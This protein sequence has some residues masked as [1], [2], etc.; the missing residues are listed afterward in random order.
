MRKIVSTLFIIVLILLAVGLVLLS[1]AG[2]IRA[3]SIYSDPHHFIKQ[4]IKWIVASFVLFCIAS[5]FDYRNFK[6]YSWITIGLYLGTAFLLALTLPFPGNPF[7]HEA[8]GSFRWLSIAGHPIGQPSEFAKIAI[9]ISMSVWMAKIGD[10]IRNP[11][12]GVLVPMLLI[13]GFAGSLILEPDFGAA[14]VVGVVALAVMFVAGTRILHLI[15]VAVVG[16]S[17]LGVVVLNNPN[18]LRRLASYFD[19]DSQTVAE[20]ASTAA[21]QL[22]QSMISFQN[23]GYWGVGYNNSIQRYNYLPEAHTDFI[24]A[25][26]GEEFGFFFSIIVL[27]LFLTFTVCGFL[28]ANRVQDRLGRLLAFSMTFLLS[29]QAIFNIGVVTGCLPTKGIALPFLSYGG[30]NLIVAMFS[31]GVLVNIGKQ[32]ADREGITKKQLAKNIPM[33]F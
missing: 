32:F 8:N 11:I 19:K 6:R 28:I 13:A 12:K 2:M 27:A 20:S 7:C 15:L 14:F 25:I 4:Q 10:E 18:R 23:G 16:V 33:E 17:L 21:H 5:R 24:F 3:Q 22:K 29:F 9:A 1:S 31:V 30:T 26:G